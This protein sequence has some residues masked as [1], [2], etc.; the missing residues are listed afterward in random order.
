MLLFMSQSTAVTVGYRF[1]HLSNAHLC[2]KNIGLNS[3]QFIL[4]FSYFFP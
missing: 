1:H 3:S 2:S 4:G